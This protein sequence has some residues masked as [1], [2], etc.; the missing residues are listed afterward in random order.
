MHVAN[1][2]NTN[3]PAYS[4]TWVTRDADAPTVMWGTHSGIYT[5]NTGVY[6]YITCYV[7]ISIASLY[8]HACMQAVSMTYSASDMCGSPATD[9]GFRDPGKIHTAVMNE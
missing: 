2:K 9:F 7:Y 6:P 1:F 4:I 8:L 3:G 5:E